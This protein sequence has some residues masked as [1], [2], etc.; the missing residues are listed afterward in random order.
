MIIAIDGPAAS[1]KSTTA[2]L[3]AEK[4]SILYID[5]GAMYRAATLSLI[6]NKID[7]KNHSEM[8]SH[9]S[10]IEIDQKNN[11]GETITLLNNNNV[12]AKIRT[13]E[14]ANNVSH[15][16]SIPE[17]REMLVAKQ[18]SFAIRDSVI[19]DGRDIG[20]IVFP[21]A[22]YK[23]FMIAT[24]EERAKRRYIEF[25]ENDEQISLDELKEEIKRR[26][27]LDEERESSPLVA[28]K[29]SVKIDTSNKTIHEQV[30][31]ILDYIKTHPK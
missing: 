4:L 27:K 22:E 25:K 24:V 30:N 10:S 23:F 19:M 15:V 14:I 26:D 8:I 20:T 17:I 11:S 12:N 2:K 18:R 21:D 13:R 28:A 29:D 31:F 7:L 6:E 16:A 9:I 1:G 3:I 5:S